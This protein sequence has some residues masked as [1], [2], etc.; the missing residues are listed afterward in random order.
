M[1]WKKRMGGELGCFLAILIYL[2]TDWSRAENLNILAKSNVTLCAEKQL[3]QMIR[4][5]LLLLFYV[6]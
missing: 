5:L 4:S 3:T 2:V 6:G 1:K